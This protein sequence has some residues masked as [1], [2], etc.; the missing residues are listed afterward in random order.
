[1]GGGIVTEEYAP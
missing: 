1:M